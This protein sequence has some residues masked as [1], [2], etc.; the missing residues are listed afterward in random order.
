MMTMPTGRYAESVGS[1]TPARCHGACCVQREILEP[2]STSESWAGD[3]STGCRVV[4]RPGQQVGEVLPLGDRQ[5]VANYFAGT[6]PVRACSLPAQP[7]CGCSLAIYRRVLD[8]ANAP[9]Q[10][11]DAVIGAPTRR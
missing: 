3:R 1:S 9:P 10:G 8:R 6:L 4:V 5:G 11:P 7:A 2:V